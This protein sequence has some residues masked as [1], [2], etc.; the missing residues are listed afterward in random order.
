[1]YALL[2]IPYVQ[3]KAG[4]FITGNLSKDLG[5]EVSIGRV[6]L[7]PFKKLIVDDFLIKDQSNDTLIYSKKIS[8]HIDSIKMRNKTFYLG[9]VKASQLYTNFKLFKDSNNFQFAIDSLNSTKKSTSVW[10]TKIN[11]F[12]LQNSKIKVVNQNHVNTPGKF[13]P[14]DI[15]LTNVNLKV[16]AI[17]LMKDSIAFQVKQLSLKDKCDFRIKSMESFVLLSK[18]N[19]RFKDL[20]IKSD[21]S[22]LYVNHLHLNY[23]SLNAFADFSNNVNIDLKVNSFLIDFN[24]VHRFIR[25]LPKINNRIYIN[26][27]IQGTLNNLKGRNVKINAGTNT[28]LLTNFDINDISNIKECYLYLNVKHLK[29]NPVDLARI[30]TLKEGTSTYEV[31]KSFEKLGHIEFKGIISGFID[32]LV[33]YG[34]FHTDLGIIDTDL[35]FK[36][37]D[38]KKLIYSG[39]LNTKNLNLGKLIQSENNLNKVTMAISINGYRTQNKQ[40]NSFIK[41]NID[42][43]EYNNY[44]YKEL[45]LNGLLS[46]NKFDGKLQLNDPNA[47]VLFEGKMDF[48][49]NVPQFDFHASL[50][51]VNLH[52]L[53]LTNKFEDSFFNVN[54]SSNLNG[55]DLNSVHGNIKFYDGLLVA[56]GK[57]I[58]LDTFLIYTNNLPNNNILSIKSDLL[59]AKINGSYHL[60]NVYKV[61]KDEFRRY[62]P[63]IIPHASAQDVSPVT[64]NYQLKTKKLSEIL[65]LVNPD[66]DISDSSI[67]EGHYNS[68]KHD[69]VLNAKSDHFKLNSIEAKDLSIEIKTTKDSL[70]TNLNSKDASF[71]NLVPIKNF[72]IS[73]KAKNNTLA[74]IIHWE[75]D[76]SPKNSGNIITKTTFVRN[77]RNNLFTTINLQPSEF[78]LGDSIWHIQ[79]SSIAFNYSGIKFDVFRIHHQ[80][81][82]ISINGNLY[83]RNKN[84]LNAYFQNIDLD[85]IT[86]LFDLGGLTFNGLIN[87]KI[88]LSGDLKN[89]IVTSDILINDMSL[90][91]AI[92][93]NLQLNSFWNK[94]DNTIQLS[95]I[96]KHDKSVP[97]IGSGFYSAQ[98]N[99]YG[100]YFDLDSMP[101]NFLDYYLD[102]VMQNINGTASGK[103]NLLSDENG[104]FI[105]TGKVNVNKID[106][107][108][109]LLKCSFSAKD[110]VFF[111]PDSIIFNNMTIT[112]P[113]GKTGKFRGSIQHNHFGDMKYDLYARA[114]NMLIMNTKK[115]DNPLYYG[116]IYGSGD[117]AIT[118]ITDDLLLDINGRT[119]KNTK[120]SIPI[121]DKTE[122]LNN[123]FIRFVNQDS[124]KTNIV[125]HSQNIDYQAN[126]SNLA[127]NLG[128]EI[129][130]EAQIQVIFDPALGDI[131][132]I[133][134]NGN[135]QIQL[136]KEG[137][138]IFYGDYTA[139]KG[140]YLFSLENVVNKKFEIN[141]GGKVV[142]EGDPYD[143]IIDLTATYKLKTSIQP[144]IPTS[145]ESSSDVTYRRIPIYCDMMLSGHLSQPNIKFDIAAPTM[146]QS[147]QT[148]I[149]DAISTEEEL[150]RQ[151][152]SL[153]VLNKFY[154]PDYYANSS[155]E[156]QVNNAALS[157]TSE[158]LSSQLS[159]WLSQI[160]NDFDIGI[161]YRPE[162][163]ISSE[164]LEVA[165]STE[166]F[167]NRVTIDGNVEYGK[168][169][170]TSEQNTNNIVGDFD[171]NVKLNK[172]GNLR[173][174]A[175]THTND[176]YSYNSS[177]TTQGVGISYQ[178]EFN[179]F[180]ELVRKYWN[181]L[182][183][184]AK[185]E[186]NIE[187]EQ[188]PAE[189]LE[190]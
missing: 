69:F 32:N 153:L 60:K 59:E 53:K 46:N 72:S 38:D 83:K 37:T 150:N 139:E 129:T 85:K 2:L 49:N 35:G 3:N 45:I 128:V 28:E 100:F 75:S 108:I 17:N 120:F 138:V 103:V 19:T 88:N 123:S 131:L 13:N 16:E 152:L 42:S 33:T 178:E 24:D 92:I 147:T 51:H 48:R 157:N 116:T 77:N 179:T 156:R 143:A 166:I 101:V 107:N 5:V 52:K 133:W 79:E 61:L 163:E 74:S 67:V 68:Q 136:T 173:A 36:F 135:I 39:F 146:E 84:N 187:V 184:Q 137:D 66:F 71:Y 134:G 95:T 18:K 160:S 144:L 90:N 30:T 89:P 20:K 50:Q 73:Q 47:D 111:T 168:Y 155:G 44:K 176:D 41:G 183:G 189:E 169:S 29:T 76:K 27:N 117:I 78:V 119:E 65:E 11:Q 97:L 56:K 186:K 94:T 86:G 57:T 82:E 182:T 91:D 154:T 164:Q 141:K 165:L 10:K 93:G 149:D 115:T 106:F 80:N 21:Y 109:D 161:S 22:S 62:I 127:I 4:N 158:M 118:G 177:L 113:E 132:R 96:A 162:N 122:S 58:P 104:E 9:E 172:S 181:I 140:D 142:W 98:N 12:S 25:N 105:L 40:F 148:L 185:K 31:P 190:K 14:K 54:I 64:F 167:N 112:D 170:T 99:S 188:E 171:L 174:K 124:A 110:S 6:H 26:G 55:K 15:E 70:F 102:N 151:I 175:Y 125:Q 145:S 8:A 23:D 159:N 81:Q 126:L 43:I 130:P 7:Y 34:S 180:G 63:A 121:S 87:G 1:M 114:D